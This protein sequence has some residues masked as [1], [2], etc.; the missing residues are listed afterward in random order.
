MS[1]SDWKIVGDWAGKVWTALGPLV[2]VCIG[3]WLTSR[4]LKTSR[5]ADSKK[6]EYRELLSTLT[7]TLKTIAN[8]HGPMSVHS[9]KEEQEYYEAKDEA[10]IAIDTRLFIRKE[11][12][13]IELRQRWQNAA[14]ELHQSGHSLA[15]VIT[16]RKITEEI[17]DTAEHLFE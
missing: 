17:K 1:Q 6:D 13:K 5:I 4:H 12:N 15:F 7:R 16:V 14:Q 2:G 9:G 8:F 3:A 11:M 10:L